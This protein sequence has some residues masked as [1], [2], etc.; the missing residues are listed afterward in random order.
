[1]VDLSSWCKTPWEHQ[2]LSFDIYGRNQMSAASL[3]VCLLMLIKT[4]AY[5]VPAHTF[6]D[7]FEM[8]EEF[9][10]RACREFD[11]AIKQCWMNLCTSLLSQTSNQLLSFTNHNITLMEYLGPLIAPILTGKIV[12]RLGLEYLKEKK[13]THQLFWRQFVITI[14]FWHASYGYMGTFNNHNILN[15]SPFT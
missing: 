8:S 4:L 12:W 14:H 13:I 11:A 5:N 10:W 3:K 15:L 6:L 9:G 7:Y 1:M 2:F